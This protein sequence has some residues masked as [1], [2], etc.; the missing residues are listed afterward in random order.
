MIDP[1]FNKIDPFALECDFKVFWSPS[2]AVTSTYS[3]LTF[4]KHCCMYCKVHRGY[5]S[6]VLKKESSFHQFGSFLSTTRLVL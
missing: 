4:N 1:P 3:S 2:A 6:P 5:Q